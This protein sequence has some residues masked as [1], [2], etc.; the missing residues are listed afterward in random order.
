MSDFETHPI[1]TANRIKDL[2]DAL[3]PFAKFADPRRVAPAGLPITSGSP[4]A[5]QQLRMG[6]CYRAR[7]VLER[8]KGS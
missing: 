5:R 4:L 7:D 8:G 2:E 6:D 3:R 1:G